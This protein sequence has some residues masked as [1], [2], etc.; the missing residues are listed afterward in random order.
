MKTTTLLKLRTNHKS[1]RIAKRK[2]HN[3]SQ[4]SI[5]PTSV[6]FPSSKEPECRNSKRNFQINQNSGNVRTNETQNNSLDHKTS[7]CEIP[8]V[9][10]PLFFG[11]FDKARSPWEVCGTSTRSRG[12]KRPK[13]KAEWGRPQSVPQR[14]PGSNPPG[15]RQRAT[16]KEHEQS[17]KRGNKVRAR[18]ESGTPGFKGRSEKKTKWAVNGFISCQTH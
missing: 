17:R 1:L 10:F 4:A 7:N 9:S 15:I 8:G 18:R 11:F 16:A 2:L 3:A 13:L 5:A 6:S 12:M 14:R